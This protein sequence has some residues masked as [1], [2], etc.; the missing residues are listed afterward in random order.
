MDM[1]ASLA[2]IEPFVYERTSTQR[3]SISAEHGLGLMKAEKI[4]YSKSPEAVSVSILSYC[5]LHEVCTTAEVP[6]D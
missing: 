5:H 3:G 2:Q 4:H 1:S 6:D